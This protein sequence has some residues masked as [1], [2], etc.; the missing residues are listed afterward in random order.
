[1]NFLTRVEIHK[2]IWDSGLVPN[3]DISMHVNAILAGDYSLNELLSAAPS[4]Y[5]TSY[6]KV[7]DSL[8]DT[9]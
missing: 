2:A 8:E 9:L 7:Q 1:M 5:N 3:E 6:S 4:W